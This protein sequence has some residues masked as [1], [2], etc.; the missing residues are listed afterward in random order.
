MSLASITST[1]NNNHSTDDLILVTGATGL[2]GSHLTEALVRRGNKVKALYRSSIP[3][4]KWAKEV[5]WVEGDI[6]DV[7]AL[8][9]AMRNVQH[10]YHCAAIV[11]F[12]PKRKEELFRTNVEG[13]ANVVNA[14]IRTKVEKLLFVSSVSALGRIRKNA[15]VNES[16]NWSEE[17]SN[18]DYGKSKYL[19]EM[20]V[21][22]GIGEGLEAVIVN[23]TI[24]LGAADWT[25]GSTEIFKT[26][27][28]EF[29][30]Y[31]DGVTGFVDVKDVV[32]AMILLM[33]N[34]VSAQRFILNA[35]NLP[36]KTLFDKIAANFGSRAPHKKVS[37]FMAEVVWRLEA[38]KGKLTGK[39]PLLTKET[40]HTAQT[41]VYFDN[42][43]FLNQFPDF[44]YTPITET[45]RRICEE[46]KEMYNLK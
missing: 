6:L 32:E 31:T 10:V 18:S 35:E 46:L 11:S 9:G 38:L 29:P 39:D 37:P 3:P 36:Y 45:V 19:A 43:R 24:V 21:W 2:I 33:E 15:T 8:E 12:S 44:A 5:E 20:E 34:N 13:T 14:S 1:T 40:A 4:Q 25:K 16:M 7:V 30:W 27:Y 41:K 17:T 28:E 26:M 42:S 23:P 22:R